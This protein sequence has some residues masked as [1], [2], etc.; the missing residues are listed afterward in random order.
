MNV[1]VASIGA[2]NL[3]SKPDIVPDTATLPNT[4]VQAKR[5]L[6][7]FL[8]YNTGPLL[9]TLRSYVQRMGLA[10]GEAVPATA[11]EVLQ[12]T[13]IEAL[14]HVA[15]FDPSRQ[16]MAWLLGIAMN[17]IKRKKV[18]RAKYYQHEISISQI[19]RL[20]GEPL[21]ESEYFELIA[22]FA[23]A[24]PEQ[25]VEADEQAASI[26]A[27]VSAE[28]RHILRLAY[29]SEFERED[30][31]QHLGI[32]SGAARVRLHRA[33][34]R[35]RTAWHAQQQLTQPPLEVGRG[36]EGMSNE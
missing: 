5:Q 12:E 6:L 31:A 14:D 22:P 23:F 34:T 11:L 19:N 9:G 33:L 27:L 15:R 24:G 20:Q 21:S 18:E 36:K 8:T 4:V 10:Q 1:I 13:V 26:L 29:I 35:L 17:I 16:P 30:L 32:T 7:E 2:E 28:D 25:D 3:H